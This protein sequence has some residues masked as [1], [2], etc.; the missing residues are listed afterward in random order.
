M[1]IFQNNWLILLKL[2]FKKIEGDLNIIIDFG[3]LSFVRLL[4]HLRFKANDRRRELVDINEFC[5]KNYSYAYD[6]AKTIV[7]NIRKIEGYD[8]QDSEIGYLT[9]HVQEIILNGKESR[10]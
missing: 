9:I 2:R 5:Q 7:E 10:G 4:R 3:N 8:I 1:L 6:K